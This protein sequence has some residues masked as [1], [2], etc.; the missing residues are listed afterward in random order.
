MPKILIYKYLTF[1]FYAGDIN[2][3]GHVHVVNSKTYLF[4]SKIWF[5]K[6]DIDGGIGIFERG[7]LSEAEL[8]IAL[9]VVKSNKDYLLSQWNKFKAGNKT[10]IKI[11]KKI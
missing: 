1:F 2:E 9:K 10:S 8:K 3:P 5:D 7:N 11:L 4:A 6:E